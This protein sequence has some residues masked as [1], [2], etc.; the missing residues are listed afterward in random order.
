[1]TPLDTGPA[2]RGLLQQAI[3]HSTRAVPVVHVDA[4]IG[5]VRDVLAT[6][7]YDSARDVAV[8]DGPRLVGLLRIEDVLSAAPGM[9]VHDLMDPDPPTVAPGTDQEVAAW[10][11]ARHGESSVAV[12]DA[13]GHFAGLI[14]PHRLLAVLLAEHDEDMARLGGFLGSADPARAASEEPVLRRFRHRLPWLLLGLAGAT[15]AAR[16]VGAFEDVLDGH[17]TVAFFVPTIVY[18]ADAVGTQTETLIIRG[19]SV[20]VPLGRVARRE[21]LTGLLIGAVLASLFLP[22]G[23]LLWD[24][25]PTIIAVAMAIFAACATATAVAMALPWA[26]ARTGRDP[27]YGSGPLATVVQD[28]LSLAIYFALVVVILG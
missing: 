27:A 23:L 20:G 17:V 1:M 8:C 6:R 2:P 10:K 12:V 14:P 4:T 22:F 28:L 15:M 19:L 26:L 24:D 3:E 9:S 13:N 18:M 7:R 5:Q 16:L 21:L 11:A 25:T